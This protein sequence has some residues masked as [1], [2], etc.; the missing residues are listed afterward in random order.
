MR[1]TGIVKA[2]V[3]GVLVVGTVLTPS[4]AA[5][6]T[7]SFRDPANDIAGGA[8]ILGVRVSNARRVVVTVRHRDL[9]RAAAPLVSLFI[10]TRPRRPGPEF[11]LAVNVWE[12]Y[13][14]PTRDWQPVGDA[15]LSCRHGGWFDYR[16]ETTSLPISRACLRHPG[17]VRVSVVAANGGSRKDWAPG[18][19]R[20]SAWV[21]RG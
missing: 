12:Y 2:L 14:W 10:D 17:R 16:T 21:S 13:L 8:D 11:V 7:I 5:A 9:R 1:M 3:A 6:D 19:H 18:H 20:F 15:P 4:A